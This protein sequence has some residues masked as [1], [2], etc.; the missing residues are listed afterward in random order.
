MRKV[1][2][3]TDTAS[4]DA[5]AIIMALRSTQIK[6]EALTVVAGNVPLDIAVNN[7][8]VSVKM[9]DTYDVPVYPGERKPIK[10]E[11]ETGQFAHG[12]N[13]MGDVKLP[14]IDKL[15]E[16]MDA[17]SAIIKIV[18]ENPYDI[19]IIAIGPLTNIAKAIQKAPNTMK[20]VRDVYI[21]GGNGLGEGN[22]TPHA[23]F[24]YYVDA[25]AVKLVS[26]FWENMYLLPWNT[27]LRD[28]YITKD[29][30]ASIRALNLQLGDF[31][32][33][34]NKSLVELNIQLG[35][36]VGFCIADAGIVAIYLD[37]T[38][39]LKYKKIY[40]DVITDDN[41]FYGKQFLVD[42]QEVNYNVCTDFDKEKFF[43]LLI[44]LIS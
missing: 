5:V 29:N 4:D 20:K 22:M 36:G 40:L 23:E 2:I 27:C 31:I 19:D 39:A 18:D 7:A 16:D 3:D 25:E 13:G 6:V 11:L 33:D 30:I 10:R 35:Q 44:E 26:D 34:I 37:P 32:V 14:K 38:I 17:V 42:K 1:I 43:N 24:N 41:E 8:L 9:A 21:M 12:Q 15:P 28:V